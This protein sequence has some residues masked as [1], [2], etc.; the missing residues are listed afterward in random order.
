MKK[1]VSVLGLKNIKLSHTGLLDSD[2]IKQRELFGQNEILE[3]SGNFWLNL[4]LETFKDPMIWFL[5]VIGFLF[6]LE[7]FKKEL[8][9]S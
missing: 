5:L 8:P 3:V 6:L 7:S 1:L 4:A 9:Y 2:V